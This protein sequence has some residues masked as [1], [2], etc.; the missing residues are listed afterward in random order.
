MVG[1][2]AARGLSDKRGGSGNDPIEATVLWKRDRQVTQR[3]GMSL[4]KA[5][6]FSLGQ[7]ADPLGD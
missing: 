4:E 7:D 5:D 1:L 3:A 2:W 6:D